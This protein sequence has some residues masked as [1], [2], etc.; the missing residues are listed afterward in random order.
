MVVGKILGVYPLGIYQQAYRISSLPVTEMGEIF[1]K[2]TFPYYSKHQND[3]NKLKS[4]FLKTFL[5]TALIVIPFGIIIILY[6]YQT[7]NLLLGKNWL[8]MV[9]VLQIL[10]IYG[11]L[12]AL[13]NSVFPLFLGV[14]KQNLITWITLIAIFG[15]GITILPLTHLYGI[16]GTAFSTIIG[17]IVTIPMSIYWI[18]KILKINDK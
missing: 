11:I 15:M 7:V 16:N 9:G 8:E 14:G 10:A 17:T 6:P 2:V 1:S 4:V 5:G 18:V 12:K 3:L 13:T